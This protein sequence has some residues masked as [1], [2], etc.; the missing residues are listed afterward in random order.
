MNIRKWKKTIEKD[1]DILYAEYFGKIDFWA[2]SK[3]RTL[4]NKIAYFF[5]KKIISIAKKI[6]FL[7]PNAKTYS[8][9]L[10]IIA[11]KK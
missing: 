4:L 11:V 8:P 10:G 3:K 2:D 9:Y 6:K 1:T 7:I 5:V